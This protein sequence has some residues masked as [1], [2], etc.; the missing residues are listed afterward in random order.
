MSHAVQVLIEATIGFSWAGDIAI[1]DLKF[2]ISE[3]PPTPDCDFE[4]GQR[5]CDFT[6]DTLDDFNWRYA[7]GETDA[8]G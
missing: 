3:C 4:N 5:L 1:D 2:A 8:K 6:Q 7:S